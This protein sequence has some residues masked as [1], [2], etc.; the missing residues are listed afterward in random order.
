MEKCGGLACPAH[1]W[2]GQG[3]S[4]QLDSK[5]FLSSQEGSRETSTTNIDTSSTLLNS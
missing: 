5:Y 4:H 1:K 3:Q 2:L